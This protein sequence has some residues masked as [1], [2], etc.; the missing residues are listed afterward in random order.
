M[1]VVCRTSFDITATG[2]KSH[3]N[4]GRMPFTD[5]SG[6]RIN[7]LEDWN[8]ARNQQRNWETINQLISLR[9]LPED[10]TVPMEI[11]DDSRCWQFEF[12]VDNV[13]NIEL[14][15]D[16]VGILIQDCRDVPMLMGLK[17]LPG[18]DPCLV[19]GRNIYFEIDPDK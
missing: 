15:G 18:L 1:R 12:T 7:T 3:Y 14:H 11:N 10:I 19:P 4:A 17:E 16:P 2:V 8:R 9:T 5:D 6:Q 13:S